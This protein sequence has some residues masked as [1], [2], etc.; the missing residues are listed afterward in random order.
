M[1]NNINKDP[2]K[3]GSEGYVVAEQVLSTT[4]VLEYRKALD[5][6]IEHMESGQ[7]PENLTEPH[8]KA[9]D[10]QRWLELCRHP[11]VLEAVRGVLGNDL[12][13]LMS[14]LIVKP[15]GD[16]KQV[17]WHQDNTY[18]ASVQGSD[19]CT[20]WLAI[21][22]ST[23]ENGCLKVIPSTHMGYDEKQ[24]LPTDADNLLSVRVHVS[25]EELARQIEIELPAGSLSIHDSFI[26]HG[27]EANTSTK[28]RA[29]F[30]MRYANIK[31]V[32]I[33]IANHGK[34]VYYV[35][36]A[37]E[38]LPAGARDIRAGKPL[39]THPGEHISKNAKKSLEQAANV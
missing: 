25:E 37:D 12:A 26:L 32:N 18:W 23:R 22:D 27:S 36:G 28:R 17:Q 2:K 30:T 34:P 21:D 38:Y 4:E 20:V 29:G 9:Q 15:A 24:M 7:R 10:W 33:D 8:V 35:S 3:Y 14:H 1:K 6:M 39:P 19:I 16:G 11:K 13:L 5:H 31:T